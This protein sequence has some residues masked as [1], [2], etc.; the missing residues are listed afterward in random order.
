VTT[1]GSKFDEN[2]YLHW[3]NIRWYSTV[4]NSGSFSTL[5]STTSLRLFTYV[6]LRDETNT[7]TIAKLPTLLRSRLSQNDAFIDAMNGVLFTPDLSH[8]A[9]ILPGQYLLEYQIL[10]DSSNGGGGGGGGA[11]TSIQNVSVDR[12][13]L[14]YILLS[15]AIDRIF[16]N[17]FS[18][19]LIRAQ[20]ETALV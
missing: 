13:V 14:T 7:T 11:C 18:A 19:W 2:L 10:V 16:S 12:D 8:P 20:D 17:G 1:R 3:L 6:T 9:T 5:Y 15:S 4:S